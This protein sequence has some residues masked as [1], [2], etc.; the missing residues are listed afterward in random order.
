VQRI[1][2]EKPPAP[3]SQAMPLQ[4]WRAAFTNVETRAQAWSETGE[5]IHPSTRTYLTPEPGQAIQR[6]PERPA[7]V[8]RTPRSEAIQ[9]KGEE[10][11]GEKGGGGKEKEPEAPKTSKAG[12]NPNLAEL[13]RK[14]YPLIKRMLA[15]EREQ[16]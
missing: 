5:V 1:P 13:A 14:V 11:G 12:A 16:H 15:V 4:L 10:G 8:R 7:P 3:A 9:R 6:K 2:I